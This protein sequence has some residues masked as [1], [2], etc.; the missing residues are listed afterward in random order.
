MGSHSLFKQVKAPWA[1]TALG[2]LCMHAMALVWVGQSP[3]LNMDEADPNER[4]TF[5]VAS[6]ITPIAAITQHVP[7]QEKPSNIQKPTTKPATQRV[8]DTASPIK[9][10]APTETALTPS[11]GLIEPAPEPHTSSSESSAATLGKQEQR[12]PA[13][14]YPSTNA[15]YFKNPKP[16]YPALSRRLNEQGMVVVRVLI[17]TDGKA[18]QTEVFKSSGYSRL[19]DSA[20]KTVTQWRFVPGT[21]NGV[22]QTMWFNVPINFVLE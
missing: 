21:R 19:D 14:V 6:L 12:A 5:V 15:A 2:V 10:A 4:N 1:L 20:L 22:A 8:V 17:D 11:L 13:V 16:H 3:V 18:E 7:L 9:A